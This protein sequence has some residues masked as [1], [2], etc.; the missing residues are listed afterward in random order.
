MANGNPT[1][2]S[3]FSTNLTGL[4]VGQTYELTFYQGASQQAGL[5]GTTTNDQWIVS[6]GTSGLQVQAAGEALAPIR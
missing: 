5:S 6:L 2:D 3:G 4:T 1:T